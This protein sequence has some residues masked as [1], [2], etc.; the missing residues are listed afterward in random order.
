MSRAQ[1]RRAAGAARETGRPSTLRLALGAVAAFA[2]AGGLAFGGLQV[3]HALWSAND[4]T[5]FAA[6]RIGDV[7][8]GTQPSDESTPLV[9][10][11]GGGSVDVTIP[12]SVIAQVMGQTSINRTP[13]IWRFDATGLADGITGLTYD[14]TAPLQGT[15][16]L[17]T[18]MADDFSLLGYSDMDIYPASLEGDCSVIPAREAGDTRNVVVHSGDDHL[19]HAPA[20][21]ALTDPVV[22]EWCVAIVF[23]IAPDGWYHNAVHATGLDAV[24]GQV[25]DG[26]DWNTTVSYPPSLAAVGDYLNSVLARG[27]TTDGTVAQ[28]TDR[29]HAELFPDP[30]DEPSVTIRLDPTVTNLRTGVP[31]GDTY[32]APAP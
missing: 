8:F 26:A 9:Y 12:G 20:N 6:F 14:V 29:W 16:D 17:S 11:S 3:A 23:R 22:Q 31:P 25:T 19:L 4:G 7:R 30:A 27:T 32:T 13:V 28:D 15:Q 5:G 10:S 24:G 2:A 21:G 1:L 18:G